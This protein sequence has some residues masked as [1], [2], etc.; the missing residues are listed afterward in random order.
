MN[1]EAPKR[2]FIPKNSEHGFG[3][4]FDCMSD[5]NAYYMQK[6]EKN[7]RLYVDGKRVSTQPFHHYLVG[8]HLVKGL[9][10]DG[11]GDKNAYETLI[12]AF[13]KG[14]FKW[15]NVKFEL[16]SILPFFREPAL[17][18]FED[19]KNR[20]LIKGSKGKPF[21]FEPQPKT[22]QILHWD[23]LISDEEPDVQ[24]LLNKVFDSH[25]DS[26][27]DDKSGMTCGDFYKCLAKHDPDNYADVSNLLSGF[28]IKGIA[29]RNSDWKE[30]W[31]RH[32]Y[33]AFSSGD[34]WGLTNTYEDGA[35]MTGPEV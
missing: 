33:V 20:V 25:K 8:V 18:V 1:Q 13:Q 10:K 3:L 26:F 29:Y 11:V 14:G 2:K 23:N 9:V 21:E 35:D 4:Q 15:D 7:V 16:E 6:D 22:E 30:D 32:S 5:R 12:S 17:E 28:N 34:L 24:N 27:P 31:P 19:A